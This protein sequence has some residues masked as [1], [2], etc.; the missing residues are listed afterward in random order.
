MSSW[1]S[2]VVGRLSAGVNPMTAL[3]TGAP[4]AG[5]AMGKN[6]YYAPQ[7]DKNPPPILGGPAADTSLP[8]VMGASTGA[9]TNPNQDPTL[10]A[11]A[12]GQVQPLLGQLRDLYSQINGQIDTYAN[13][14]R[15]QID[16][17][18]GTQFANNDNVYKSGVDTINSSF[19]ARGASDSSYRGNAL[20]SAK[21][22]YTNSNNYLSQQHDSNYAQLG[23]VVAQNKA[24][25]ANPPQIDLG[26]YQDVPSLL[27][28]RDQLDQ[29]ISGLQ[30]TQR[31]LFTQGQLRDELNKVAPA[32]SGLDA[33][34]KAKIDAL[35]KSGASPDA[36]YGLGSGYISRSGLAKDKQ[37]DLTKYLTTV[38]GKAP[39]AA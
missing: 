3:F 1:F 25:V 26:Q 35:T 28:L 17:S 31:N 24:A 39:A 30:G 14:Q 8:Q 11:Q 13:D 4:K 37:N 5:P 6:Q 10:I 27:S 18:Y 15:G 34:L 7:M 32:Q 36:V 21:T 33:T 23:S 2:D 12:R 9:A 20:D 38:L 16:Q 22:D 29:H 19:G